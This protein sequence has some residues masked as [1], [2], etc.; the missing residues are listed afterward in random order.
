[1]WKK[2]ANMLEKEN[3]PEN[4]F[5]HLTMRYQPKLSTQIQYLVLSLHTLQWSCQPKFNWG[6]HLTD[7]W[8]RPKLHNRSRILWFIGF[9]ESLT[10]ISAKH[11]KRLRKETDN[12]TLVNSK[13]T[14]K[15]QHKTKFKTT[16]INQL[17]QPPRFP[18]PSIPQPGPQQQWPESKAPP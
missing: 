7:Q 1:M 13:N 9:P 11:Y 3:F 14:R 4:I 17:H 8:Y 12:I 6:Q 18:I 15:L 10:T 5:N 2:D 16:Q